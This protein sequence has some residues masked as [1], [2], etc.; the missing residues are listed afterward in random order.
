MTNPGH[1]DPGYSGP[2]RFTV[3]NMGSEPYALR[4]GEAIVSLLLFKLSADA[5]TAWFER[6]NK[7]GG[8]PTQEKINRLCE[9]FVDVE[10]RAKEISYKILGW[11]GL[12]ALA[13]STAFSL[14]FQW[15]S[16]VSDLKA[17]VA[18]LE[19]QLSVAGLQKT[20]GEIDNRL[21]T[22]EKDRS[23]QPAGPGQEKPTGQPESKA[24]R[25]AP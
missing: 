9:D 7:A 2:M 22:V 12:V 15:Y 17:K 10:K 11:A 21:K 4:R 19:S 20:V 16:G 5:H 1:V 14:L 18:S 8:E 13:L 3:I 24:T 6:G 25:K 23:T